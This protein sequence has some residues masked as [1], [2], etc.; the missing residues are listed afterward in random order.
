MDFPT[1]RAGS[2]SKRP[3]MASTPPPLAPKRD[4]SPTKRVRM[5]PSSP[6]TIES[7][8]PGPSENPFRTPEAIISPMAFMEFQ[9][10]TNESMQEMKNQVKFLVEQKIIMEQNHNN[11]QTDINM[12]IKAIKPV[13]ESIDSLHKNPIK[14]KGI[15]MQ[16]TVESEESEIY[17]PDIPIESREKSGLESRPSKIPGPKGDPPSPPGSSNGSEK[18]PE[19]PE[20]IPPKNP[21]S[22]ERDFTVGTSTEGVMR[23]KPSKPKDFDGTRSEL[24]GFLA[25]VR[26]YLAFFGVDR[27]TTK[28]LIMQSFFIGKVRTWFQPFLDDYLGIGKRKDAGIHKLL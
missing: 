5:E 25:Q 10:Q 18:G 26:I 17:D 3:R 13:Q 20:K 6:E 23:F 19:K 27:E 15:S 9:K 12:L 7:I 16:P 21:R 2:P 1:P 22:F 4:Q 8:A 11:L 24:K 14:A 28:V